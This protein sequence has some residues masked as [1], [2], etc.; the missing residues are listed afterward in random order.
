MRRFNSS[1][2]FIFFAVLIILP[3]VHYLST[4][5]ERTRGANHLLTAGIMGIM[6]TACFVFGAAVILPVIQTRAKQVRSDVL[7]IA[8]RKVGFRRLRGFQSTLFDMCFGRALGERGGPCSS[9][10]KPCKT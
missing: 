8:F 5:N 6:C 3:P 1:C 4:P 10:S 7:E 2:V 9:S